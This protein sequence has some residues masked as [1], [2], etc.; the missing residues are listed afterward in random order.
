MKRGRIHFRRS[1]KE[2][3]DID[4]SKT[5]D[6]GTSK[7][8]TV[9]IET[10]TNATEHIINSPQISL[11]GANFAALRELCD[12]RF[13][14]LFN[15]HIHSQGVD[16]GGDVQADTGVPTVAGSAAAQATARVKGI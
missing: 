12:S 2:D 3:I 4:T 11:G 10:N 9:P 15:N 6:I 13:I 14:A 16:S 1:D 8:V 5:E 7:T